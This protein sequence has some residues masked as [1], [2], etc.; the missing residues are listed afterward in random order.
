MKGLLSLVDKPHWDGPL[1]LPL[2]QLQAEMHTKALHLLGGSADEYEWWCEYRWGK[3]NIGDAPPPMM[4]WGHWVEPINHNIA[5]HMS[6]RQLFTLQAF[7]FKPLQISW[8]PECVLK[9]V[10]RVQSFMDFMDLTDPRT[11][12]ANRGQLWFLMTRPVWT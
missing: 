6:G 8:E 9:G 4:T 10:I 3:I 12:S 1:P 2:P 7:L 5:V 11:V